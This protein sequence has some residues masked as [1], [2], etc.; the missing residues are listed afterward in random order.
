MATASAMEMSP[1]MYTATA[2]VTLIAMEKA[3]GD[4]NGGNN[5]YSYG[6]DN[7][8]GFGDNNGNG[9][10]RDGNDESNGDGD[11]DGNGDSD[12]NGDG[13]GDGN[14]IGNG[15]NDGCGACLSAPKNNTVNLILRLFL[16]HFLHTMSS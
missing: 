15:D 13:D 6:G 2:M 9:D 10:G 4:G 1:G 11:G 3:T 16:Y 8:Y 14:G 5:G 12:S 7:G